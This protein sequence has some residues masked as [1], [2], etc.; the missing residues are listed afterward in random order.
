MD[1][2]PLWLEGKEFGACG[3]EV[4]ALCE[5]IRRDVKQKFGV[6]IHPEVNVI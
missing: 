5:Q 2:R 4:V 3:E 1:D 6:D